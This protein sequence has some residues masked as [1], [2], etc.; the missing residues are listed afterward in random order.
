MIEVRGGGVAYCKE[1]MWAYFA[2]FSRRENFLFYSI[3]K[4]GPLKSN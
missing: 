1:F 2:K 4:V 3:R